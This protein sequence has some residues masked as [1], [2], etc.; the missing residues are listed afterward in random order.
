MPN[1]AI[2]LQRAQHVLE[3]ASGP[4]IVAH[5]TLRLGKIAFGYLQ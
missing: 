5:M 2:P 4:H 1:G 3:V